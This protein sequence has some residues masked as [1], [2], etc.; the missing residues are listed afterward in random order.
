MLI[1]SINNSVL[2]FIKNKSI[3]RYFPHVK[4]SISEQEN[5]GGAGYYLYMFEIML[6][7]TVKDPSI[8]QYRIP[9]Y[10]KVILKDRFWTVLNMRYSG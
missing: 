5:L 10:T 8:N 6:V 2:R 9:D 1:S 3:S 7:R 4:L